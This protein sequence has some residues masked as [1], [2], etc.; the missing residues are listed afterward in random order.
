MTAQLP[1]IPFSQPTILRR[2]AVLTWLELPRVIAVGA[3]WAMLT[4]PVLT[5]LAGAPWWIAAASALPLC[6]FGTGL[7]RF[8]AIL[9]RSGRPV[10]RDAFR[11][12]VVLGFLTSLALFGVVA[13]F[14]TAGIAKVVSVVL[15]AVVLLVVPFAYSYGAVRS[16]T[17]F[18]A[19][20]GGFILVAYRPWTAVTLLSLNV[21]GGILI[22][23]SLGVFGLFIPCYL[24]VFACAIV[25]GMLDDIDHR[26][27]TR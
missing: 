17:G 5:V 8:A 13:L 15:A 3:I 21:I 24:F 10:L 22:V 4:V 7:A 12:D 2:M 6:L 23:A 16:R 27:G 25:A 26:S 18:A 14:E 19:L 9:S 20:R 11:V 1:L